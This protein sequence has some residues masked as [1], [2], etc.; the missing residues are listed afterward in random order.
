MGRGL[1][2]LGI[3][4][5]HN[6]MQGQSSD[7][8]RKRRRPGPVESATFRGLSQIAPL[9]RSYVRQANATRPV[10]YDALFHSLHPQVF[11]Y[12]HR[13]TGCPD[14]AADVA[15]ESFVRMLARTPMPEDEARRWLF[16]V[17]RNLVRDRARVDGGRERLLRT[18]EA[19]PPAPARP[20]E[21]VE[22][23]EAAQAVR[24]ALSSL[25]ER[26]RTLLLMREEGFRYREIARELEVAPGSV[27]TLI[28][29]AARRFR[30]VYSGR[31]NDDDD[32]DAPE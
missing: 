29:R 17:A 15:Q 19:E 2:A 24:A 32:H 14:T 4:F 3:L 27:G 22:Q 28:A 25:S 7:R 26:D 9:T 20:D 12:V 6:G 18:G 1:G 30:E 23:A 8:Q 10:S 21:A 16:A 5:G 31:E 11:R 13:L